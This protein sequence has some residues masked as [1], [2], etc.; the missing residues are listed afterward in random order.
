VLRFLR[1]ERRVG[2]PTPSLG[3]ITTR[4]ELF[5]GGFV[6]ELVR[7]ELKLRNITFQEELA[8]D[9]PEV[10]GDAQL[11]QQ[12][13]Y[14]LIVNAKWAIE[15]KSKEGGVITVKTNQNPLEKT[16]GIAVS[17]TGIGIPQENMSKLFTPYFTTKGVGE[18]TGLGLALFY[19]II[20]NHKGDIS[21]ESQV[22]VGTTF[23]IK[24]P[25]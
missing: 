17:D 20:K 10:Q 16:V 11:L 23:T 22:G 1:S 9:L 25:Y 7:N 12:V 13:I 18:G 24:L 6:Y 14:G 2:G 15:K 8:A 19:N 4:P 21:V 3:I 5:R